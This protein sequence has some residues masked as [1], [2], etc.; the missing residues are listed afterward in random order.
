MDYSSMKNNPLEIHNHK[1]NTY[2]PKMEYYLWYW[3]WK[4]VNRNIQ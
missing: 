1:V 4:K 2:T 3:Q